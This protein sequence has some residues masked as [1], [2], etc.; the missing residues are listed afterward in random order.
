V[1][2]LK[3]ELEVKPT[4]ATVRLYEKIKQEN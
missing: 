3:S 2:V 1:K 4:R